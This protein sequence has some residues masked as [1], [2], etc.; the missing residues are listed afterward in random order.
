MYAG[1]IYLCIGN[2][3]PPKEPI[4]PN[5]Y[6]EAVALNI[7]ADR[8]N[9]PRVEQYFTQSRHKQSATRG[10]LDLLGIPL[11]DW[12]QRNLSGR[13]GAAKAALDRFRADHP[14]ERLPKGYE[15]PKA[16]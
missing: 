15:P 12:A 1:A 5:T 8:L 6:D 7:I 9:D 16:R 11:P 3:K 10:L 13:A 14:Q 4:M 2:S